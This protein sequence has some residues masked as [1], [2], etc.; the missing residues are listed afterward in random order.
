M[1]SAKAPQDSSQFARTEQE[2]QL[3]GKEVGTN[4]QNLAYAKN[5]DLASNTSPANDGST[6]ANQEPGVNSKPACD[7]LHGSLAAQTMPGEGFQGQKLQGGA[8]RTV[9]DYQKGYA[10]GQTGTGGVHIS[11]VAGTQPQKYGSPNPPGE[12][13]K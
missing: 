2:L 4:A 8:A 12:G 13:Q 10:E 1:D 3:G 9:D 6:K 11:S 7:E 5:P